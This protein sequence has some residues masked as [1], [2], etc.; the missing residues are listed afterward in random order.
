MR[1]YAAELYR[2]QEDHTDVPLSVL[3]E[4]MTVSLQAASRMVRRL[5]QAGLIVH[6]PYHGVRLTPEGEAQAMPAIRRHRLAEVF[7]VR[8]M[9][10]GWDEVHDLTDHLEP[11]INETLEERIAELTGHPTRCPHGEPIPSRDGHMPAVEDGPLIT[12]EPGEKVR[13]SRIRTHDPDQLRYLGQLGLKPG[14]RFHLLGRAPFSGPLQIDLGTEELVLGYKLAS[15]I[16]VEI[17]E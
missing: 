4:E 1:S 15:A 14:R 8:V 9:G 2:L 11:G 3:A 17:E 6:R 13:I 7:L 5:R 10:F 12:L 16:W